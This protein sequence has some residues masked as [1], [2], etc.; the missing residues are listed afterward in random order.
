VIKGVCQLLLTIKIY[1]VLFSFPGGGPIVLGGESR[2]SRDV[3]IDMMDP[4]TSQQ[5]QLIDEQVLKL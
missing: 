2:A 5:L 3:A 4:R 1:H